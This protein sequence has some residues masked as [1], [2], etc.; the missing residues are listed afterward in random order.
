MRL[1]SRCDASVHDVRPSEHQRAARAATALDRSCAACPNEPPV[2]TLTAE[3]MRVRHRAPWILAL[4]AG[5]V[6]AR[7]GAWARGRD[8]PAVDGAGAGRVA[9]VR[10]AA[11]QPDDRHEPFRRAIDAALRADAQRL[12]ARRT[13]AR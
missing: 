1:A 8:D 4:L 7:D 11:P 13:P 9:R 5:V 3:G 2:R 6:L 12:L 10:D